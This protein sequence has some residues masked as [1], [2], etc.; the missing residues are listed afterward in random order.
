M[1]TMTDTNP[2]V[3]RI[4]EGPY[5]ELHTGERVPLFLMDYVGN[6]G[7]CRFFHDGKHP[8][9]PDFFFMFAVLLRDEE[10]EWLCLRCVYRLYVDINLRQMWRQKP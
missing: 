3:A 6:V 9:A 1:V 4:G 10:P 5:A 8:P 2:Y 7:Q